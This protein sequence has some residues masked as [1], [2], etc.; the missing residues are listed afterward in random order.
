MSL[1]NGVILPDEWTNVASTGK[2]MNEL[3]DEWAIRAY[4]IPKPDNSFAF[5]DDTDPRGRLG[6]IEKA[7]INQPDPI[8]FLGGRFVDNSS[9]GELDPFTFERSIVVPKGAV[10]VTPLINVTGPDGFVNPPQIRPTEEEI[11][12]TGYVDSEGVAQAGVA[13]ILNDPI[14]F[15]AT[16]AVD[17]TNVT[18]IPLV[19]S[20]RN[21]D[22]RRESPDGGFS[23]R[24]PNDNVQDGLRVDGN[25]NPIDIQAQ[26]V[27]LAISDGYWY[28]YDTRALG[29]GSHTFNFSAGV[30]LAD[31]SD[32]P[33]GIADPLFVLNVTYNLL[34]PIE[35]TNKNDRLCG[36]K[37]DDYIT[38]GNGD[39]TVFGK[40]GDDVI[41]GGNGKDLISGG[42]GDDELWGNNGKD[43]FVYAKDYG[44]DTIFDFQDRLDKIDVSAFGFGNGGPDFSDVKIRNDAMVFEDRGIT[45][46]AKIDFSLIT[47]NKDDFIL[48]PNIDDKR[49]TA[50]DFIFQ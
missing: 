24:L 20:H 13:T 36:T 1:S 18:T 40:G 30:Y 45:E 49:I 50:A 38:G 19:T 4:G 9:L 29:E 25:G 14:L 10:L 41:V 17:D 34:N 5:T 27:P 42:R 21:T 31:I 15:S 48:L 39:D 26:V 12:N 22:Y 46:V 6:S 28:A 32:P 8:F 44:T 43:T 7:N 23:Y 47:G 3:G 11:R 16:V 37:T 35:G 2:S 33:D